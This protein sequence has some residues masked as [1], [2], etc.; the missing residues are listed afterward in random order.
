MNQAFDS[1]RVELRLDIVDGRVAAVVVSC[2]RP[3]V[4]GR[5]RGLP[6]EKAVALL[7]LIYSLCGRAQGL[8]ARLALA[9]ARGAPSPGHSD[10]AVAQEM[11][12]EHLW[13]LL[14]DWP[15]RLGLPADEALFVEARR[16]LGQA[17]YPD[18]ARLRLGP[19]FNGLLD[20]LAGLAEPP[21][22]GR[23][24]FE[25]V[26]RRVEA[27]LSPASGW[28]AAEVLAVGVG[29]ATVATARGPLV[30]TL[31]LDGEAIADYAIRAPTDVLFS[32]DSPLVAWLSG[33]PAAVAAE[34]APRAV[35]A[36][37]PCVP[38]SLVREDNGSP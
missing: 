26:A 28:V 12:G 4:A 2:R 10:A 37:D 16:R 30:H 9:A 17:D 21:G 38:W 1:G 36:L 8:A 3:A 27:A 6:A 22:H 29:R 15:K 18:W 35:L 13:R 14:L 20:R 34:L 11:A 19:S 25:R 33:L 7:P 24:I 32:A 5:L 23:P 31:S